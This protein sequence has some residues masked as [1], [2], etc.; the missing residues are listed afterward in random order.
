MLKVDEKVTENE[1]DD[2][3]ILKML[4]KSQ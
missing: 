1:I 2:E 3:Q 4:S